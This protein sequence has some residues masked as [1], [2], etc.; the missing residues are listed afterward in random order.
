MRQLHFPLILAVLF[1]MYVSGITC[2]QEI[3]KSC[4]DAMV[5]ENHNHIDYGPLK[6]PIIQGR[7]VVGHSSEFDGF[8]VAEACLSLFSETSHEYLKTIVADSEG[9][10]KFD[11][12]KPGKYRLIARAPYLCPANIPIVVVKAKKCNEI[13]TSRLLIQ[14]IAMGQIDACSFGSLE[15]NE[16]LSDEH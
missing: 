6:L 8:P 4:P 12:I 5:Y 2:G 7:C 1:T 9:K 10:F 14:F 15:D 16:E 13:I 11:L 3:D